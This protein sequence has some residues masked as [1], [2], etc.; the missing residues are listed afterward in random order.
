MWV[1]TVIFTGFIISSVI[2]TTSGTAEKLVECLK[3]DSHCEPR[4]KLCCQENETENSSSLVKKIHCDY[5]GRRVCL[6]KDQI[7]RY[8]D[9]LMI[10][11]LKDDYEFNFYYDKYIRFLRK[12]EERLVL[13]PFMDKM[14]ESPYPTRN[15]R[16]DKI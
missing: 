2:V 11:T 1:L 15:Y 7:Y 16:H 3:L 10:E 13:K 8:E 4:S 14:Y 12:I 9:V 5:L 6:E